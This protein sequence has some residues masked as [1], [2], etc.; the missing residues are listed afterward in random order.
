MQRA[1]S[2]SRCCFS[3]A[4]ANQSARD[5]SEQMLPRKRRDIPAAGLPW[6]EAAKTMEAAEIKEVLVRYIFKIYGDQTDLMNSDFS[7]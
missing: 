3:T 1:F 6:A 7:N 5:A 4:Q 2:C